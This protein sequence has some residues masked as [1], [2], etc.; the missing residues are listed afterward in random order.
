MWNITQIT[1]NLEKMEA[2]KVT[3]NQALTELQVR[4]E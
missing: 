4:L 1:Q 2:K 3:Q